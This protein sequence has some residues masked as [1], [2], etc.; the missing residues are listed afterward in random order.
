MRR[1]GLSRREIGK[2]LGVSA[3][4]ITQWLCLLKLPEEKLREI[5]VLGDYWVTEREMRRLRIAEFKSNRNT[6]TWQ[7][8]HDIP[9]LSC[10]L[11]TPCQTGLYY[12]RE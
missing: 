1:L 5:E 6:T 2:R 4:R 10:L 7:S 3:D 9:G 12:L 8:D 11:T